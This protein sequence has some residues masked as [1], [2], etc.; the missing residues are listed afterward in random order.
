MPT[1]AD[2]SQTAS[3]VARRLGAELVGPGDVTLH[4][5]STLDDAGPDALTFVRDVRL[6]DKLGRS[7]AGAALVT[8]DVVKA[9]NGHANGTALI[10]V[11][12]ADLALAQLLDEFAPSMHAPGGVDPSSSIDTTASIG[13]GA[14]VG[15]HASIGPG[16]TLGDGAVMHAGVRIGAGVTIGAGTELR[17][18]VVIEDRCVIGR[19]VLM[20]PGVVIGADGFGYRPSPDGRGLVKIPHIGHVEIGDGVEIGANTTIDRGKLGATVIGDGT[21]IDN[22]VQIGHN[23]RVGRSCVICGNVGLSGSVMVGDGV[24]IAGGAGVADGI[25][26]GDGAVVGAMSGVMRDVPAGEQWVGLPA[27]IGREMMKQWAAT[28][29]LPEFIR[30]VRRSLPHGRT[31][32]RGG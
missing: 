23:C 28:A 21:K 9:L 32:E 6:V 20:H 18:N 1:G 13:E 27:K 12:D 31:D 16:S 2:L 15:P 8:P 7:H 22:L 19:G 5:V 29:V 30:Q 17:A 4:R 10:V 26:I 25:T 11:P 24:T 3:E 14:V